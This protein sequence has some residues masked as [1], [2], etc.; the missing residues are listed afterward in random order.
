MRHEL[1]RHCLTVLL[2][3]F[4]AG[5]MWLPLG[6]DGPATAVRA[7]FAPTGKERLIHKAL[8]AEIDS[9]RKELRIALYQFTSRDL[10][11]HVRNMKKK[12]KVRVLLDTEQA[13][14]IPISV[15]EELIKDGVDV[16]FVNPPGEGPEAAKF[17]HKFLV[18]DDHTVVTGSY[19]W[20]VLAD[21][22]NYEN[23]VIIPEPAP[24]KA[25]AAEFDRIWETADKTMK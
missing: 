14:R 8:F 19:N 2:A 1:R 17:H 23:I 12:V 7:L 11:T 6:G 10:L 13:Q 5:T 22:D 4:L 16:R 25:Y 9:A 20:T 24:A 18:V 3:G 15:H 21:E